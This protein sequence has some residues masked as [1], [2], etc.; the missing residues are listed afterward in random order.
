[1]TFRCPNCGGNL[2]FSVQKQVLKCENCS[3]A[4]PPA[5]FYNVSDKDDPDGEI[6]FNLTSEDTSSDASFGKEYYANLKK[7]EQAQKNAE[8]PEYADADSYA[9]EDIELTGFFEE[10]IYICRSCGARIASSDNE[11]IAY[12]QFCG[13]ESLIPDKGRYPYP[14]A[15]VPFRISKD[16]CKAQYLKKVDGLPF[17][18]KEYRSAA[19]LN[20]FNGFYIPYYMYQVNLDGDIT[21]NCYYDLQS[22]N[23]SDEDVFLNHN[24]IMNISG[25]AL[26]ES[27]ASSGFPDDVSMSIGSFSYKGLKKFNPAY[28]AGF[29]ADLPD[30]DP[31][32]YAFDSE[33]ETVKAAVERGKVL[34]HT[35][36]PGYTVTVPDNMNEFARNILKPKVT[37]HITAAFPVW[38]LTW[39]H[40]KRV[41]YSVVNGVSGK[42]VCDLPLD[43]RKM[44]KT[45]AL[46]GIP[47]FII[48]MFITMHISLPYTIMNIFLSCIGL[49]MTAI[50]ASETE[51]MV[52]KENH[53]N[54]KGFKGSKADIP[55]SLFRRLVKKAGRGRKKSGPMELNDQL[56]IVTLIFFLLLVIP[57]Y[58]VNIIDNIDDITGA[59]ML[60]IAIIT[61]LLDVTII[62][63]TPF[64]SFRGMKTESMLLLIMILAM[65]ALTIVK[66]TGSL[67]YVICGIISSIIVIV[68]GFNTIN[69]L[70][71]L[72][73]RKL[74]RFFDVKNMN[75]MD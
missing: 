25:D 36:A 71:I 58:T 38:F 51:T 4:F 49:M 41:A 62:R 26:C 73:S 52:I 18:P 9:E 75:N 24:V 37:R 53:I 7:A 70:N 5:D 72:S 12:C 50:L 40:G 16:S 13:S 46:I 61:I 21:Y 3:S 59:L 11:A 35:A 6:R 2:R 31:G 66:P 23:D 74:P 55:E 33:N 65:F 30:V 48:L 8:T 68:S 57:A 56:F 15:I 47:I 27:D 1:M 19:F 44:L 10:N 29:Y 14:Q 45:M 34:A 20:S 63:L 17:L 54:D 60:I 39:K 64:C 32:L 69:R 67:I 28:M 22:N 43:K 42:M